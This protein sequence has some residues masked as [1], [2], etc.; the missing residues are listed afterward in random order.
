MH[1]NEI[2]VVDRPY[3]DD[4]RQWIGDDTLLVLI[5]HA[6]RAF[7]GEACELRRLWDIGD[8]MAAREVAHKLKGS[9][10]SVG[11]RRL[12]EAALA[13][14]LALESD[15]SG[16]EILEAVAREV[17]IALDGLHAYRDACLSVAVHEH[18]TPVPANP[19]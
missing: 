8:M 14:Q 12:S 2:P 10:S 7:L 18:D 17:E 11:C 15:N 5:E 13:A 4:M 3:L 9:A 6:P 16:R 19:Q 1:S